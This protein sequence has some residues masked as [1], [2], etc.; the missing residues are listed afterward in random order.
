MKIRV[1]MDTGPLVAFLNRDPKTVQMRCDVYLG[2]GEKIAGLK[3]ELLRFY[4]SQHQR[5]LN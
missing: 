3:G 1:I 2:Y 5:N 4:Q